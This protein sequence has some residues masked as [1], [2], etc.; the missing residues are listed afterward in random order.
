MNEN[1]DKLNELNQLNELHAE[2]K[3]GEQTVQPR[4]AEENTE[5]SKVPDETANGRDGVTAREPEVRPP[6][7]PYWCGWGRGEITKHQEPSTK[8]A[9]NERNTQGSNGPIAESEK[10]SGR[11]GVAA[12][13]SS[14]QEEKPRMDTDEQRREAELGGRTAEEMHGV[15][16][17]TAGEADCQPAERQSDTLRYGEVESAR[18]EA[19]P[20]DERVDGG[21]LLDELRETVRRYVVLPE[22]GA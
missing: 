14:K 21:K 20:P 2:Q 17:E 16:S 3:E 8:E 19:R 4:M 11:D 13:E 7:A 6:W 1:E 22:Y 18:E 15:K 12:G 5:G 9:S 10:E